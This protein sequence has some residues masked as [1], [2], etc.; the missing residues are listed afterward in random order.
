MKKHTSTRLLC[1]LPALF[2]GQIATAEDGQK[3]SLLERTT[4]QVNVFAQGGYY[5]ASD[6]VSAGQ[7]PG[8]VTNASAHNMEQ[9]LQLMH[10]ELGMLVALENIVAGKIILGSHHGENIEL[11][12]MWL[13]PYLGQN[14]QLRIGRQLN[15]IGLYNATHDHDWLFL[16]ANLSQQAFLG[17]QYSDD[18]VQLTYAINAHDFTAWVS[19]GNHYPATEKTTGSAPQ[20]LGITYRWHHFVAQH[21][22][23]LVSSWARFSASQTSPLGSDGHSHSHHANIPI[24]LAGDTELFTLGTQWQWQQFGWDLELMGQTIDASIKDTQ[25]IAAH[26]TANNIGLNSQWYWQWQNLQLGLRYEWLKTDNT[27][28]QNSRDFNTVLNSK[29]HNPERLSLVANWQFSP[30]HFLR[31][32][33]N[34]DNTTPSQEHAYWLV[35]QGNLTW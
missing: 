14:W 26:L 29:N 21:Q 35:Y 10:A 8:I 33:G 15:R 11:E 24:S 18:G 25:Q 2:Y 19:R 3:P 17:G 16:D 20:A 30:G 9:G 1:L 34:L 27:L 7:I 22:L 31:I 13:Q 5:Q 23:T 4:V 32:Q 28:S 6:D 12:E